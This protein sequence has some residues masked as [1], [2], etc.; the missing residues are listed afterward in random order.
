MQNVKH[1][2]DILIEIPEGRLLNTGQ[3]RHPLS[4]LFL[5]TVTRS[6]AG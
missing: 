2:V 4:R 5:S 3:Q 6:Q 1:I